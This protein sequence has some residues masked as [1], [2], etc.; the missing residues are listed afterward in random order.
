M[1]F[2]LFLMMCIF[3]VY[4]GM[5]QYNRC[6]AQQSIYYTLVRGKELSHAAEEEYEKIVNNFCEEILSKQYLIITGET[7]VC[8][9]DNGKLNLEYVGDMSVPWLDI[10]S[11]ISEEQWKVRIRGEGER[12]KPVAFIRFCNRLKGGS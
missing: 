11:D 2:P 5:Y 9:T 1:I 4:L 6:V 8:Q 7:V 10:A 3:L 12:W